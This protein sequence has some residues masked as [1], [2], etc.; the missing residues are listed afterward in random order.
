MLAY[1][2]RWQESP[3]EQVFTDLKAFIPGLTFTLSPMHLSPPNKDPGI[4]K[5][6][7]SI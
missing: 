7:T 5:Q 3:H 2:R 1:T 6:W 4:E